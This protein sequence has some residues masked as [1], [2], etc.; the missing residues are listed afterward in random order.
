MWREYYPSTLSYIASMTDTAHR[1][2]PTPWSRLWS[3]PG[4]KIKHYKKTGGLQGN[5]SSG[6]QIKKMLSASDIHNLG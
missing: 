2:V 3:T 6:S 4:D 1:Y 5:L